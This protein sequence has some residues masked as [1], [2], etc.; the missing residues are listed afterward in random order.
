MAETL[1]TLTTLAKTIGH[2]R[3]RGNGFDH[4]KRQ[5]SR[6]LTTLPETVGHWKF[7]QTLEDETSNHNLT[8][9]GGLSV[10]DYIYG[11]TERI[12]NGAN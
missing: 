5:H 1:Y 3:F 7:R 4:A 6:S 12:V 11:Y 2:W 9:A 8:P 10:S